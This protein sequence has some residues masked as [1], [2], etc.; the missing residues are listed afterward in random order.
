MRRRDL[1]RE[2]LL[3]LRFRPLR[4]TL[5]A[6]GIGIGAAAVVAVV[7]IPASTQAGL[8]DRLGQDGN[9]LTVATG[10]TINGVPAPLPQAAPA[11][12]GRIDGV[13]RTASVAALTGATVRRTS[14]IPP[15]NTNGIAVLAADAAV[16]DTLNLRVAFGR[17][18]DPALGRYPV[19]VLGAGAAQAL[20]VTRLDSQTQVYLGS[21]DPRGGGRY[22]VVAGVLAPSPLAPE[23]DTAALIGTDLARTDLGFTGEPSRIYLRADPDRVPTVWGLLAA[24]ANP[25]NPGQVT[26]ARPSDLLIAR[27][28][29]RTALLGLALGL[30]AVALLVGGIGVANIMVVSVLERRAEIGIRRALG[31]TRRTVALLFLIEAT[32]LC[33]IGALAGTLIGALTTIAYVTAANDPLVLPPLPLAAA[34]AGS[35]VTGLIAGCYPA[36]RAARLAPTDALR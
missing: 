28:T 22:A 35:L 20:G 15:Q 25:A 3:G 27:A 5:C 12:V 29:T 31:A 19:V 26:V 13:R 6:L 17:F 1:L 24:T 16:L 9:L 14:A 18:I 10:Q 33:L 2:A 36:M 11:M 23:L 4:A 21:S 30:G 34:L 8:L 7:A 32:T